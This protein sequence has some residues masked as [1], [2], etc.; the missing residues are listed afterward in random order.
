M[1]A[2]TLELDT[3]LKEYWVGS[4]T[5]SS[6]ASEAL[7]I[8][9]EEPPASLFVG[10][11]CLPIATR[12]PIPSMEQRIAALRDHLAHKALRAR[13]VD[14]LGNASLPPQ[15][16]FQ[17][18]G[19]EATGLALE[20]FDARAL[21]RVRLQQPSRA[22]AADAFLRELGY[23]SLPDRVCR[24][25]RS[26]IDELSRRAGEFQSHAL[27][28]VDGAGFV[29]GLKV[30][31]DE[32]GS[33]TPYVEA[34]LDMR[35]QAEVA[36]AL[37]LASGRGARWEV[38]WPVSFQG[39]S[40]GLGLFV[41]GLVA[42]RELPA[43]PLLAASGRLDINGAVLPV[44]CIPEKL[45][46]ARQSGLR[47]VL[48]P[49]GNRTEVE[50]CE[51]S[52]HLDVLFVE[53]VAEVRRRLLTPSAP[54]QLTVDWLARA[55][56]S[57]APVEHLDVVDEVPRDTFHRIVVAD[58]AGRAN[59]DIYRTG[60]V[61]VNGAA[62]TR[63][64]AERVKAR[65]VPTL[66][67]PRPQV[68]VMLAAE[69]RRTELRARL[70]EAGAEELDAKTEHELW[71]Y[72]YRNGASTATIVLY[73]T[74]SCVL[75]AGTAPAHDDVAAMIGGATAGLGSTPPAQA[76]G[77]SS[78]PT[79][80]EEI[81]ESVPHIGTDEAGKGD[82]FGPL[83]SA[84]VFVDPRSAA[85]LRELGV[86]D[87]KTLTDK[88]VRRLAEDIRHAV[89]KRNRVTRVRPATYNKLYREMRAEG[90]N[91]NTLLA[92]AHARTIEDL[93]SA[94]L[95]PEFAVV[96]KF[97]DAR[98]IER[99]ILADTRR[100]GMPILQFTKAEADVAVA[101]ASILARDGF[102]SWIEQASRDLGYVVPKGASDQTI[103][104]ARRI[105]AERGR[106][107]LAEYA[108]LNFRTTEKVLE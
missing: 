60:T 70:V 103:A 61:T 88:A 85:L 58:A 100:S 31:P 1:D 18:L 19:E 73:K 92:W 47:R 89:P 37:A 108:K 8:A 74:G 94:G 25:L 69:S 83:V 12:Y 62:A 102:L 84:G 107:A 28:E 5:D 101:A 45:G 80:R 66:P 93:L 13:Q 67:E 90:K 96:D 97:A 95:V 52:R 14:D 105:V 65:A 54:L 16:L 48:L 64:A 59:V 15:V 4:G 44:T 32:S 7:E 38:E 24:E 55:V 87:S 35:K 75:L 33:V 3:A 34:R 81:D 77:R 50:A 53:R 21:D 39:E 40:I 41:A 99:K 78:V 63:E 76:S 49:V 27:F 82:Y 106:D 36:L 72:R 57:L 10:A 11:R 42:M 56:R 79:S 29:L 104:V 9:L 6:V 98:Y 30:A 51:H 43:D 91:L 23:D 17:I 68:S 22:A 20:Q 2:A 71:R 86:R 46:A 26:M